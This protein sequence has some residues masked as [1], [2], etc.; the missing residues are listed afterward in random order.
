MTYRTK[1]Y[2]SGSGYNPHVKER[3]TATHVHRLFTHAF[4]KDVHEYLDYCDERGRTGQNI[5]VDSGAFSAWNVGKPVQLQ[6]L[7][8]YYKD[9][10]VRHPRHSFVFIALDVI[11]GER[12]R[13]ATEP[14]I[15]AAVQESVANYKVMH[16]EFR[17][18]T[19]LPVY[20]SGEAKSLR[21][22]YLSMTDYIAISANQDLAEG[23]RYRFMRE[24]FVPGFKFHGLAATGNRMLT[25]IDWYSVDS[26]GWL[27]TAAMGA[28][29]LPL[30]GGLKPVQVSAQSPSVKQRG[31]HIL[32]MAEAPWIE[33]YIESKGYSLHRLTQDHA[34]RTCW[35]IDRWN[36]HPWVKNIAQPESLFE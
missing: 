23:V 24:A 16:Q 36:E 2:F 6:E 7:I 5:M 19:I 25:G 11:P 22:L 10:I 20:H 3:L 26:S 8:E 14:E 13:V 30:K 35:N 33:Q 18:H 27:M 17:G 32:T 34:A 28:I 4:P 29:L 12:G 21:N 9:I 1:I 31:K 15:A